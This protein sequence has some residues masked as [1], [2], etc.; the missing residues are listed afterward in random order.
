MNVY[1]KKIR[2][3]NHAFDS[4]GRYNVVCVFFNHQKY[5]CQFD[6]SHYCLHCYIHKVSADSSFFRCFISNKGTNTECEILG[7]I[8]NHSDLL[9][10]DYINYLI[11]YFS[12]VQTVKGSFRL[13]VLGMA[14]ACVS[15]NLKN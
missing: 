8:I 3:K 15:E 13:S 12:E 7:V 4:V 6:N 1:F 9:R 2:E 14:C 5:F 11:M 10:I